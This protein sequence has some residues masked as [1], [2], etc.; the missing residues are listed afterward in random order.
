MIRLIDRLLAAWR[1]PAPTPV[2]LV[3][4]THGTVAVPAD[5]LDDF[6]RRS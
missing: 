2:V 1:G 4:T 5:E 3:A 6:L